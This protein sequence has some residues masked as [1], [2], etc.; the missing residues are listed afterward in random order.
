MKLHD[1]SSYLNPLI[2]WGVR[3]HDP[4]LID[5]IKSVSTHMYQRIDGQ[6]I[7]YPQPP[8]SRYLSPNPS[9]YMT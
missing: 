3:K 5:S 4:F 1:E 6:K 8:R 2:M 7:Y 9:T